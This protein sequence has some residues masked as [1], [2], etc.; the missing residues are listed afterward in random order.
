MKILTIL[1]IF[2]ST[3]TFC[4]EIDI[5]SLFEEPVEKNDNSNNTIDIKTFLKES[6]KTQNKVSKIITDREEENKRRAR[7]RDT[8]NDICYQISDNDSAVQ[9]CLGNAYST[10]SE[11]ARN[12]ILGNC[13]SLDN[14]AND[15]G[16]R[17]VCV[18]GK[19]GCYSLEEKDVVSKCISCNGNNRWARMYAVGYKMS[20]Y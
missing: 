7:S 5:D 4:Q 8:S 15:N 20:C 2:F 16:L 3:T 9:A 19:N 14:W 11:N 12:I 17:S 1:S 13:Y 6:K 18:N 10:K